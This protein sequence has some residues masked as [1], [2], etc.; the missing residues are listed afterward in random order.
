[1]VAPESTFHQ[2]KELNSKFNCDIKNSK[3]LNTYKIAK[4]IKL[5]QDH[6]AQI[7]AQHREQKS[8]LTTKSTN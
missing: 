2:N 5:H 4:I 8:K 6:Q 1:M 3:P 7:E